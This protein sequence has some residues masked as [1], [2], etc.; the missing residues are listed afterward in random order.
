MS[1][2][3]R[4]V[5]QV[6]L[7]NN[8]FIVHTLTE[9]GVQHHNENSIVSEKATL[10][11]GMDITLALEPS[12]PASSVTPGKKAALWAPDGFLLAGG[13]IDVAGT[14]DLGSVAY[15]I[16]G[17]KIYGSSSSTIEE[18]DKAV[19]RN[20]RQGKQVYEQAGSHGYNEILVNN[21]EVFGYFQQA[22]K[23]ADGRYWAY[24]LATKKESAEAANERKYRGGA[25]FDN[26]L[27]NYRRRFA[28]A[29][30]R[31][32]PLYIMT[33]EREVYETLGVNDDGTVEV[34]KQ[35]TPEEVARGR[36]GLP[37]E[38]RKEVGERILKKNLFR[39][40]KIQ[41]EAEEIIKAL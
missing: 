1:L 19:G 22:A 23:D 25:V 3:D 32:L 27:A 31:G 28:T 5:E 12:I 37:A 33:P 34:G 15:A 14:S 17:R 11:D 36:A 8:V 6:T 18:I 40:E 41:K 7:R 30:E 21:P 9:G 39:G 29:Q 38:K 10:A 2:G 4:T 24:D 35:L 20:D 13:Q 16:K 26:N